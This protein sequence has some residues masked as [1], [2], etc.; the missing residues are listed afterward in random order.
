MAYSNIS[1]NVENKIITD[2]KNLIVDQS[3]NNIP[4]H[5]TQFILNE[6]VVIKEC[7]FKIKYIGETSILLEPIKHQD[8]ILK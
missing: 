6:L 8:M 3:G 1:L 5:Q 4:K 2:L 7:T